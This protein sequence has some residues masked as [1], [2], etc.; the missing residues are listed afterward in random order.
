[1]RVIYTVAIMMAAIG[2]LVVSMSLGASEIDDRIVSSAQ[3]S[4]VF[5][6]YLKNDAIQIHSKDGAVTLTGTVSDESHLSLAEDTVAGLPGVTR[7]VNRLEVKGDRPSRNSDAW[8][9]MKVKTM[10][11]FHRNVSATGTEVSVKDG[12][13]TLRGEAESEAQKELTTQYAKDVEGVKEVR[14]EMSLSKTP[15]KGAETLGE[16]IDDASITAQAK[17]TLLFHSATSAQNT[18]VETKEGVV[19]L[20][21]KAQNPAEKDLATKLV[22]DINGVKAVV[23]TMTLE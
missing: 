1:M 13:V 7:V 19:T 23:N 4:Y 22:S 11:L 17:M 20:S 21:G 15:K 5:K 10:L 9:G 6:T 8:V 14:N 12:L 16:K 18:K 2:V 3:K